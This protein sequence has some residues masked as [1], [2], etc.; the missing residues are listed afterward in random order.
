MVEVQIREHDVP[1]V[2]RRKAQRLDLPQRGFGLV[3]P[4]I[5]HGRPKAAQPSTRLPDVL[6]AVAGIDQHESALGLDQ[7]AMRAD[8][9]VKAAAGTIIEG[10]AQRAVTAAVEVMDTH[11]RPPG[12]KST[13]GEGSAPAVESA[14]RQPL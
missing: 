2:A 9:R 7:Q 11:R 1:H 10:A 14:V 5:E 6:Q 8:I 4:D 12:Q 13:A 3:E